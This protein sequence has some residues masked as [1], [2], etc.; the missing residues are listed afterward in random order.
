MNCLLSVATF[1]ATAAYRLNLQ[2]SSDQLATLQAAALRFRP[3]SEPGLDDR[4][5]RHADAAI[6]A[7]LAMRR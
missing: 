4:L 6:S 7:A 1:D 5:Q 3:L 2:M